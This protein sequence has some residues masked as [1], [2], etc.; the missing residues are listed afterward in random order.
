ML[1]D[2]TGFGNAHQPDSVVVDV[3]VPPVMFNTSLDYWLPSRK[4]FAV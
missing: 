4:K 3:A 1:A 2:Y